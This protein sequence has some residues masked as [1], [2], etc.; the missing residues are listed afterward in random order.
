MRVSQFLT[1]CQATVLS[2]FRSADTTPPRPDSVLNQLRWIA[3]VFYCS[4][5]LSLI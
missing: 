4:N 3:F 2:A 1:E 5:R